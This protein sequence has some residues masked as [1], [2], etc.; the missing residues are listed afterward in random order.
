MFI[1]SDVLL[2]AITIKLLARQ[3]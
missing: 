1:S 2:A 3:I